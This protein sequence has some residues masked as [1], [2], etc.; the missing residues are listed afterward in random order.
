MLAK[1]KTPPMG[2]NSWDCYGASVTESEILANAEYM[3][4]NLKMHGYEYVVVDI[5]WYEPLACGCNYR[6]NA[7]L[8][9]DEYGRLLPAPNRFP[10]GFKAL[11]ERIHGLGLKF[12]IHIMRGIPRQ[13]VRKN[14]KI[15]KTNA[16]CADIAL[17]NAICPWNSDMF[18]ID[19]SKPGAYEYIKS[20]FELY[21]DWGVDFIKIDDICNTRFSDDPF[22]GR[23]ELEL[24]SRCIDESSREIV[25]SLSPGP[26]PVDRR[27][28][29]MATANMFRMTDDVWDSWDDIKRV[30]NTAK[31]WSSLGR[32]PY[33]PDCDMLPIGRLAIRGDNHGGS[34]R[35]SNLNM[36]ELR[37]MMS[38]WCLFGSPLFIGGNLPD[39][40]EQEL[41]ILTDERLLK[42]HRGSQN[43]RFVEDNDGVQVWE[44]DSYRGV[45]NLNDF[46]TEGLEAHQCRLSR[47]SGS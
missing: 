7:E 18:G 33:Y 39:M 27:D 17:K 35:H 31:T 43:A 22:G 6:E 11:S 5:Q 28:Y 1:L 45:F 38:F 42:L 12:G 40:T 19:A 2:F 24:Y 4:R 46:R 44:N 23:A 20:L 8:C 9:M 13:A 14:C 41:S 25:L 26:A 29:L 32:G 15:L 47:R 21:E 16:Y 34:D 10:S 3:A 36:T 37:S 30:I